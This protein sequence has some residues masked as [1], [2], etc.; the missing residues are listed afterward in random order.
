MSDDLLRTARENARH[1]A[2]ALARHKAAMA[3]SEDQQGKSA[4][5]RAIEALA[6]A[7]EIADNALAGTEQP[8]GEDHH[9]GKQPP[10]Q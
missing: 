1:L 7:G 2:E 10:Q 6:R 5:R 9:D 8:A 4:L 3:S